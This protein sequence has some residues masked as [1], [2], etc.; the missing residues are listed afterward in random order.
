M[1]RRPCPLTF[2]FV[3]WV[4]CHLAPPP[5]P[6]DAILSAL[7]DLPD[8]LLG[9]ILV[10]AGRQEGAPAAATCRRLHAIY[11][12]QPALWQ[13]VRVAASPAVAALQGAAWQ[14][15]LATQAR[16]LER[17]AGAVRQVAFA[18]CRPGELEGEDELAS[19]HLLGRVGWHIAEL[20][21][22]LA[23]SAVEELTFGVW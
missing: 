16:G 21:R 5:A 6:E 22:S 7:Q 13:H 12:S 2:L 15:W 23:G 1:A 19:A 18:S 11:W 4:P 14:R 9:R 3:G 17:I 10:A 20:L 8:D